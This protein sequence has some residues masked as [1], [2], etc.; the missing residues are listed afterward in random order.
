[1]DDL[2][3][4]QLELKQQLL[5]EELGSSPPEVATEQKPETFEDK[6]LSWIEGG[7]VSPPPYYDESEVE[8]QV[9]SETFAI[10]K[11][12]M[13]AQTSDKKSSIAQKISKG[14]LELA[15]A[16]QSG[17]VDVPDVVDVYKKGGTQLNIPPAAQKVLEGLR[18]QQLLVWD[19]Q[20]Q[21]LD[22]LLVV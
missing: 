9:S 7:G 6:L 5:K 2:E 3:L 8:G 17:V 4:K 18:I 20:K 11:K 10:F 13:D 16:G 19:M 1:M 22:T 21:E 14:G 12:F 15:E